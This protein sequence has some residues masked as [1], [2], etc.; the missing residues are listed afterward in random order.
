ME[1]H[2]YVLGERGFLPSLDS[3][4]F[5]LRINV[6]HYLDGKILPFMKDMFYQLLFTQTGINQLICEG[7][8]EGGQVLII[9]T[10][11]F[12]SVVYH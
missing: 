9:I 3:G 4:G 2:L 8:R 6:A 12:E 1:L 7:S 10:G 5:S 11:S